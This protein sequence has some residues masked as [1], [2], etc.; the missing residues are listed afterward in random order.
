[1]ISFKHFILTI[2][3]AFSGL[4]FT[5]C[6]NSCD[7]KSGIATISLKDDSGY[8]KK[9][10]ILSFLLENNLTD[11]IKEYWQKRFKNDEDT[12]GKYFPSNTQGNKILLVKLLYKQ[13]SFEHL[14][15][16]EIN[17]SGQLLK[18]TA[19]WPNDEWCAQD[20][21]RSFTK[22]GRY[23]MITGSGHGSGYGSEYKYIFDTVMHEDSLAK[24]YCT[25]YRYLGVEQKVSST[26]K[27]YDS[28]ILV[29]Y[30][31]MNG[32]YGESDDKIEREEAKEGDVLY[33]WVN[34]N[35]KASDSSI[36]KEMDMD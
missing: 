6:N 27:I 15:V 24:I 4:L 18:N 16:L 21:I 28:T 30:I 7:S 1:M 31:I 13:D 29:H 3:A 20:A 23:F 33:T 19:Y 26:M 34:N 12:I 8:I 11:T 25:I 9:K 17:S 10:E 5:A 14:V 22:T 2:L 32:Y 36:L 35:W